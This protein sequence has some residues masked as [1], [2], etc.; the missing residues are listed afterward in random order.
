MYCPMMNVW[1]MQMG[2]DLCFTECIYISKDTNH[3]KYSNLMS[4]CTKNHYEYFVWL[5]LHN[6]KY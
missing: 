6:K 3:I 4:S 5:V 1:M 2:Y